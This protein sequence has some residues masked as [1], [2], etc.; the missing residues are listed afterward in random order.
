LLD[1]LERNRKERGRD[2]AM[3]LRESL[4]VYEPVATIR[5][6]LPYIALTESRSL[7]VP[8]ECESNHNYAND[9]PVNDENAQSVRLQVADEPGD[10]C[11]ANDR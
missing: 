7:Q 8:R 1:L 11:V 3:L 6:R 10:S 5:G 9:D 4:G 2:A